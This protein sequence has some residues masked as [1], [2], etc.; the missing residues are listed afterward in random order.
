VVERLDEISRRGVGSDRVAQQ[1]GMG[2]AEAHAPPG[3]GIG[4][5]PG[6]TD[7]HHASDDRSAVDHGAPVAVEHPRH[8]DDV[9][10]GIGVEPVG[11][12]RGG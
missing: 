7:G 11:D 5:R 4:T 2:R 9:T 1:D 3:R 6:V 12:R 8:R 10:D